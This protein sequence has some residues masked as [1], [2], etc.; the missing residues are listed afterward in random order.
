MMIKTQGYQL[1]FIRFS[2]RRLLILTALAAALLYVLILRPVIVAKQFTRQIETS[3][4]LESVS[5]RYFSEMRTDG[6]RIKSDLRKRTWMDVFECRQRF[7]INM[8]SA[9]PN[10]NDKQFVIANHDLYATPFGVIEG[11]GPYLEVS[12]IR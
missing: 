6:A 4:D 7:S 10:T 2:L 5:R 1:R 3:T 8:K 9:I 11:R 12:E